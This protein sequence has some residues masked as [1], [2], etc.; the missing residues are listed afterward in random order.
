MNMTRV[1]NSSAI[2]KWNV[3]PQTKCD[4]NYGIQR[5]NIYNDYFKICS[6]YIGVVR[7]PVWLAGRLVAGLMLNPLHR[8]HL[9]LWHSVALSTFN[10][11]NSTKETYDCIINSPNHYC[12]HGIKQPN[13][14]L[15]EYFNSRIIQ[16][17]LMSSSPLL[18]LPSLAIFRVHLI[19]IDRCY[20][21]TL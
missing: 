12:A 18:S 19:S 6:S 21:K 20:F 4:I 3:S 7:S 1:E 11:N 14:S 16:N 5:Q 17:S 9:K 13:I 8:K 15:S 2:T 10:C